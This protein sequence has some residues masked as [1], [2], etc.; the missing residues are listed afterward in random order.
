MMGFTRWVIRAVLGVVMLVLAFGA[1]LAIS[2]V[3]M[4]CDWR[5]V[6]ST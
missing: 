6:E 5:Y 1:L 2:L 4:Y 3:A